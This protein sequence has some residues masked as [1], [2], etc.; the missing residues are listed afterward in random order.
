MS[1]ASRDN[2]A[3][4]LRQLK[5]VLDDEWN[6][7]LS[8]IPEL[9]TRETPVPTPQFVVEGTE[10]KGNRSV[11]YRDNDVIF[12]LDDGEE[13]VEASGLGHR[14][15][16]R[17]TLCAFEM[18]TGHSEKRLNGDNRD[19]Y[20]GLAGET[21]RILDKYRNGGLL[22]YDRVIIRAYSD[23]VA[24]YGAGTWV[25]QWKFTMKVYGETVDQ[26]SYVG[27]T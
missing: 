27:P 1:S 7:D 5:G 23:E 19:D 13:N 16:K 9:D 3:A 26:P 18:R 22:G 4:V 20:S 12:I 25:A 24:E 2:P 8:N 6:E 15:R 10:S 11:N 17:E 14:S 21:Q